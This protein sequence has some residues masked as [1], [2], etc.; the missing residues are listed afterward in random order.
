MDVSIDREHHRGVVGCRIGVREAA[1]DRATIAHL[2][3]ADLRSRVGN[4]GAVLV[5]QRRGGDIVVDGAGADLDSAVLLANAGEARDARDVNQ[6][7]RLVQSKLHERNEAVAAGDE[8]RVA[9]GRR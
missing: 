4:D 6:Q 9:L 7:L 2:L 3:I 8:L 5:Q 1:A